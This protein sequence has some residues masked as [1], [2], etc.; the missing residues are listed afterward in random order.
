M[1]QVLFD[2]Q[3]T[4]NMWYYKEGCRYFIIDTE[5]KLARLATLLETANIISLDVET[6][7]LD[8][9][10]CI[11]VGLA[12]AFEPGLA[13]YIPLKHY[14]ISM[15]RSL[16]KSYLKPLLERK[17][18]IGHNLKFDY[19][20][21][22]R[23]LDISLNCE[24]DTFIL[25]KLLDIFSSAG[26]KFLCEVLFDYEVQE[27]TNIAKNFDIKYS[28][29]DKLL[30]SEIY[31]YCCQ[32]VDL[33]LRLFDKLKEEYQADKIISSEVYKIEIELIKNLAEM[34]MRGVVVDR[35]KLLSY[36]ATAVEEITSAENRIRHLLDLPENV[37]INSTKQIAPY[38]I[39]KFPLLKSKFKK[40]A[41]GNLK[42]DE[43]SIQSYAEALSAIYDG[44]T[45]VD[46]EDNVFALLIKRKKQIS[47]IDKYIDPWLEKI[48]REKST[49]IHTTFNAIGAA[50]GRMSSTNPN[51]QNIA[52]TI[53]KAIVPRDNYYFLSMDYDQVEYRILVA[54]ADV[55]HLMERINEGNTDIHTLAASLLYQ[56]PEDEVT[57]DIRKKAKTLNFGVLYGMGVYKLAEML[58]ISI[59]EAKN[60]RRLYQQRFL[61]NTLW[62]NKVIN[63]AQTHGYVLT[64]YGRKRR[65]DNINLEYIPNANNASEK[66]NN[67]LL[68]EAKRKAINTPIQGT[69]ADIT[70]IGLNRV[71]RKIRE[72]GLDVHPVLVVHDEI[73]FEVNKKYEEQEIISILRPCLEI[74]FKNKIKLTVDYNISYISW[75][76]L[77]DG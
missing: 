37:N 26:L 38:I 10:D 24:H 50:T 5:A 22:K 52:P 25:V 60:L 69:S 46:D 44:E 27:L 19:K 29:L 17:P 61:R 30:A 68:S 54:L 28:E 56:I 1:Q 65:I 14:D 13:F 8:I 34:E 57:K 33:V 63:F 67:R 66:E 9:R 43:M 39:D 53:R 7:G 20:F 4:S 70:K 47:L 23:D 12:I 74:F 77:K 48:E 2:L 42:L 58:H 16:V 75:G 35:Q 21:I 32:D 31:E 15:D 72:L 41:T 73:V 76:D 11:L 55:T 3:D 36:K 64:S 49:T 18:I 71:F 6:T 59:E 40:T 62:F 45:S 51:M